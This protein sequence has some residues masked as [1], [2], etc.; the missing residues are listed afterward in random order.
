MPSTQRSRCAADASRGLELN[1]GALI[2]VWLGH[3]EVSYDPLTP[4]DARRTRASSLLSEHHSLLC[5]CGGRV[6]PLLPPLSASVGPRTHSQVPSV[7]VP[8]AQ[9][10]SGHGGA[11]TGLATLLLPED[12][13]KALGHGPDTV[14]Q[15]G[16]SLADGAQPGRSCPTD[17]LRSH[18]LLP[19]PVDDPLRHR[20]TLWRAHPTPG[21]PYRQFAHGRPY[22]GRQGTSGSG[23][24]AQPRPAGSLTRTL[25]PAQAESLALPRKPLAYRLALH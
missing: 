16:L 14:P 3:K 20:R 4:T 22:P 1:L 2:G 11:A 21:P 15:E 25:E 10:E 18:S 8:R 24:H 23:R 19:Y 6:C 9:T 12:S 17:Q 13:Q 7:F 5:P